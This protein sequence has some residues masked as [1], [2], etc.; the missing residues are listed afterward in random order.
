MSREEREG[1]EGIS[2]V[3]SEIFVERRSKKLAP[4]ARKKIAHGETVGLNRQE[5]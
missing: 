1:G 5:V 4:E 3:R 2:S